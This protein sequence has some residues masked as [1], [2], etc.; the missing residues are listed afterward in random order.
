[1][2]PEA[3]PTV[4][5]ANCAVNV[6]LW[7]AVSVNGTDSP[8]ALNPVPV[9]LIAEMV[10]LV[11]PLFF[12]VIVCGLLPPTDTFPNATLP[13]VATKLEF[14]ATPVP[15]MLTTCGE[16][17]ALSVKV[18]LPTSAPVTVGENCALKERLSPPVNVFGRDSPLIP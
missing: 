4:V 1:M 11:F 10:A 5:G 2:L 15:T 9:E 6:V 13:G 8:V 16:P 17:G 12:N 3:A 14:V 18:M 7:F